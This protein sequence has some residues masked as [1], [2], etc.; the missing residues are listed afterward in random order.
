[1]WSGHLHLQPNTTPVPFHADVRMWPAWCL[2]A[3]FTQMELVGG[4]G[5]VPQA[6][7]QAKRPTSRGQ[8]QKEGE[9]KQGGAT[10][11][12]LPPT[13]SSAPTH[14]LTPSF[15]PTPTPTPMPA[16]PHLPPRPPLAYAMS[17]VE[18]AAA[19]HSLG[20]LKPSTLP[21]STL[22]HLLRALA[23]GFPDPA[24]AAVN[25][26]AVLKQL[27][28]HAQAGS[29]P[30]LVQGREAG[31]L[32]RFRPPHTP[33][34]KGMEP[35]QLTSCVWALARLGANPGQTWLQGFTAATYPLLKAGA[36]WGAWGVGV[37]WGAWGV[38]VALNA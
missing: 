30:G 16:H 22:T 1:M 5:P 36:A 37:A 7:S 11:P 23:A 28:A 38:W 33:V 21:P 20:R 13:L 6:R 4:V 18:A 27:P 31:G 26:T 24:A 15:K 2:Q 25:A 35:L 3:L 29:G 10:A 12:L 14:T 17:P 8:A 9:G 32:E 34:S 19:L